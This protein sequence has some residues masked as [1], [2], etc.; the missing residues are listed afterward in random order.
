[1]PLFAY[2]ILDGSFPRR[3]KPSLELKIK[4]IVLNTSLYTVLSALIKVE[5][6]ICIKRFASA[7]Q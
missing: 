7:I 6:Q 3:N 1:M 5:S 4:D 2:K